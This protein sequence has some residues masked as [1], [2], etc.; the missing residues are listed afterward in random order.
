MT[1]SAPADSTSA[2]LAPDKPG[3][4]PPRPAGLIVTVTLPLIAIFAGLTVSEWMGGEDQPPMQAVVM[5]SKRELVAKQD[6]VVQQVLVTNGQAVEADETL[7]I[8]RTADGDDEPSI[9]QE[10]AAARQQLVLVKAKQEL[11]TQLKLNEIDAE[12]HDLQVQAADWLKLQ[13]T[14]QLEKEAWLDFAKHRDASQL[15]SNSGVLA[16]LLQ[17]TGNSETS[18]AVQVKAMLEQESARNSAEVFETKAKLCEARIT[19]LKALRTE[20]PVRIQQAFGIDGLNQQ[21]QVLE[22]RLADN[23][24][25]HINAMRVTGRGVVTAIHCQTGER[26]RA[27]ETL[28]VVAD[29]ENRFLDMSVPSEQ[30][31]GMTVGR[32]FDISF[33][34][35][36]MREGV[37]RGQVTTRPGVDGYVTFR[38][39]AVG[40]LWPDVPNGTQVS[41]SPAH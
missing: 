22:R 8:V 28:L 26:I 21:I 3:T 1:D 14:H 25:R 33:P 4:F 2:S 10:L 9:R 31:D 38:I 19:R 5:A 6:V 15:S 36:N 40:M 27:G 11:E 16:A 39:D 37:I 23:A 30:V 12:L 18:R 7:V 29:S 35:E 20:L 41:V 24:R 34:G 13:Y 17:A 32:K